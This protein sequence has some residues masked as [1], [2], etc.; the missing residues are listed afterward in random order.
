MFLRPLY[1][2]QHLECPIPSWHAYEVQSFGQFGHYPCCTTIKVT[3]CAYTF[4]AGQFS[5]GLNCLNFYIWTTFETCFMTLRICVFSKDHLI[6]KNWKTFVYVKGR[7]F[8]RP[9]WL[10]A[11]SA[12]RFYLYV[13][14]CIVFNMEINKNGKYV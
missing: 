8:N 7:Q 2:T 14:W 5:W 6:S 4:L 10:L 1:T 12:M 9:Y 13:F 11:Y 3:Q